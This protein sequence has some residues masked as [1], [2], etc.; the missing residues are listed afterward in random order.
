MV[1]G[2]R[3]VLGIGPPDRGDYC[4]DVLIAIDPE[5]AFCG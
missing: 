4:D 3:G 5:E 2:I 1:V